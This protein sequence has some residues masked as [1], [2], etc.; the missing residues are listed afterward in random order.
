M[1]FN[2]WNEIAAN[3]SHKHVHR[4]LDITLFLHLGALWRF[5]AH[6]KEVSF[7]VSHSQAPKADGNTAHVFQ[8]PICV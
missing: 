1:K 6:H 3:V 7:E 5:L 2:R 4:R 8:E